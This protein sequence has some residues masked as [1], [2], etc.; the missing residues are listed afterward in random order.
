MVNAAA[1]L[2]SQDLLQK[3]VEDSRVNDKNTPGQLY[4]L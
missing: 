3:Q 1:I 4:A 2:E